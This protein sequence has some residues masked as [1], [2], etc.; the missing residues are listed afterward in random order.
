[1]SD[2]KEESIVT[3]VRI[4]RSENPELYDIVKAAPVRKRSYIV[5]TYA[6]LRLQLQNELIELLPK[7]N[8]LT[9]LTPNTAVTAKQHDNQK[10]E[11]GVVDECID[12]Y[13]DKLSS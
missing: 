13:L 11:S 6:S 7:L 8:G 1:M 12:N 2:H 5:L 3:K 10:S 9:E 4:T